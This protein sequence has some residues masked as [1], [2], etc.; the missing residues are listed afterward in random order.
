ML[1]DV[2]QCPVAT[3]NTQEG[4]AQG[5]AILASVGAG[6]F[7]TVAKACSQM[8]AEV[9]TNT[10]DKASAETYAKSRAI[11]SQLYGDLKSRFPQLAAIDQ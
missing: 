11:F 5:A 7:A 10:P 3:T 6:Q 4:P 8:I 2:F 9:E 1:A